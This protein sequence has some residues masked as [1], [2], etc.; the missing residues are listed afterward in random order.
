MALELFKTILSQA[1]TQA[2]RSTV[3]NPLGWMMAMCI[4]STLFCF[5]IQSYAGSIFFGI[6]TALTFFLYL[7]SYVYCLIKAPDSLRSERYSLQRFAMEKGFVGDDKFG[8]LKSFADQPTSLSNQD[9]KKIE[10]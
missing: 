5:Y 2:H 1:S 6:G 9:V 3:L 10:S 8:I 4:T 7:G